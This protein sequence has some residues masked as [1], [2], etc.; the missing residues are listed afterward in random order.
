MRPDSVRLARTSDV[1]DVGRVQ[2]AAWRAAYAESV[3][4]VTWTKPHLGLVDFVAH[5]VGGREV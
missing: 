3:D 1:D 2:V 5:V 4:G